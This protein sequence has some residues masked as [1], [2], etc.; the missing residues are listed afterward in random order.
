[1]RPSFDMD[2]LRTAV[3]GV[4]LGSFARAAG[5]LG[6]SQSAVSMQLKKLEQQAGKQ[7]F[8]RSGRGLALTEAG[9]LLLA[10]ARR[11]I[12]LNDEVAASLGS[13][14]AEA[15]VRIGLPQDFVEDVLPEVLTSFAQERPEI[16][17]E[18]RAGRN[19]QIEDEVRSGRLD[20]GL[21]FCMPQSTAEGKLIARLPLRWLASPKLGA[22]HSNR[23][24]PL[25]L[26]D[27][28]CLFRQTALAALEQASMPWR[29]AFTTPS[30]PGVWGAL[31]KGLGISARTI[32]R[33]PVQISE[34]DRSWGLPGLPAIEVRLFAAT[35]ISPAAYLLQTI[36]V[37][38]LRER[39]SADR[40]R[41]AL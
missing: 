35:D 8:K 29:L 36:F 17:V 15:A 5:K 22:R 39:L 18:L 28:P 4:E 32:H 23:A 1:M 10:Y 16:H 25:V 40:I 20:L 34:V 30:L 7:L 37:R 14:A 27:Y 38:T 6:R 41:A 19:Y 9:E 11:I 12:A 13:I 3:A 2:A 33:L 26:F 21:A 24:I 31:R